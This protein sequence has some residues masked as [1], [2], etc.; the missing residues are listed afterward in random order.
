MNLITYLYRESRL[1]CLLAVLVSTIGSLSGV[2]MV[3]VINT[4]INGNARFAT[5]GAVFFGL[6]LAQFFLRFGAALSVLH[7]AQ[8]AILRLRIELSRK[9]LATPQKKLQALGKHGLLAILTQD[10][11]TLTQ[12]CQ[13]LVLVFSHCII[14]VGCL[15]YMAWLSW[16]LVLIFALGLILGMFGLH[17]A[18]QRPSRHLATMREHVDV[19]YRHFRSLIE[20]SKEL[21]LNTRRGATFVEHVI[22]PGAKDL[23][24]WLVRG[25]AGY[26]M[27]MNSGQ[28]LYFLGLGVL[29]FLSPQWVHQSAEAVSGIVIAL[30]F[31]ST[32][33]GELMRTLPNLQQANIALT[34]IR[35]LDAALSP[36]AATS[37]SAEPF[38]GHGPL[39]LELKGICHRY[40]GRHDDHPF[41]LGPLDLTIRSGEILFI[42]G[43]NGSGK[44]TLAMMLLGLYEPEAGTIRL[45]GE[46]VTDAN[47]EH[48][49]QYFSAVFSDFH[50]FEH[51]FDHEHSSLTTQA[52][53]YLEAFGMSHQV[54]I[55]EGRFSTIDLSSGQRKRLALIASYLEDRPIYLFDEWAADQ[56]PA[57]RRLFYT[58]LLP[59][60]KARRKA[61]IVITHDDA[62]FPQA[63]RIVTLEEGHLRSRTEP[64]PMPA[65]RQPTFGPN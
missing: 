61:V 33:V 62:Y 1:R 45:N 36:P 40:P 22:T 38:T 21:Q 5:L 63:D 64:L 7:L 46:L 15:A 31:M 34:K 54:D 24:H 35:Q 29:L 32:S 30:L 19:L 57:F 9:L 56:D 53:R 42:V 12:A 17:V 3:A 58:E 39:Q 27:I 55:R 59:E 37:V 52:E 65:K 23:K 20:G 10:I 4:A 6:C 11:G 14:I 49:R 18:R 28:M 47:R 51:V 60:L 43:G 13:E 16:E 41:T 2:A 44:T 8:T 48:Y 50:L 25:L 26:M